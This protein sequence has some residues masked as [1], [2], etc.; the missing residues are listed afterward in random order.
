MVDLI[1]NLDSDLSL[2]FFVFSFL[3]GFRKLELA[4]TKRYRVKSE[5]KILKNRG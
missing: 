5:K 1:L 3:L 4:V 2:N